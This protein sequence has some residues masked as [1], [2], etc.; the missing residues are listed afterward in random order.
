VHTVVQRH[1]GQV[2]VHSQLGA[3][4]RFELW[5]PRLLQPAPGSAQ[6]DPQ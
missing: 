6:A 4:A 1:G 3:G 5:L 2:Q